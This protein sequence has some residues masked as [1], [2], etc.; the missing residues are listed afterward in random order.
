[1]SESYRVLIVDDYEPIHEDFEKVFNNKAPSSAKMAAEAFEAAIFDDEP[2]IAENTRAE[3]PLNIIVDH[4]YQGLEANEMVLQAN[5]DGLPYA[6]IFMDF[7]MPPGWNGVQTI[8]EIRKHDQQ[9]EIVLCTA[10]SDATWEAIHRELGYSDKLLFLRK[11]FDRDQVRDIAESLLRKW[12]WPQ[13]QGSEEDGGPSS[14]QVIRICMY[15]NRMRGVAGEW[16]LPEILPVDQ[17]EALSHSMCPDCYQ[18][19]CANL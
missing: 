1:M 15:C 9:A 5:Q 7:R 3:T 16:Q 4:A 19:A 17:P 14:Q 2:E 13:T 11:P 8:K 18:N 12:D 10:Y 6:L